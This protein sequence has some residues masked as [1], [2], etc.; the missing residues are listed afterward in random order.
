MVALNRQTIVAAMVASAMV[1]AGCDSG[2]GG[3]GGG[4]ATTASVSVTPSLGKMSNAQV[5]VRCAA[6]GTDMGTGALNSNGSVDIDASGTCAGP[7]VIRVE[8]TAATTY[9]DESANDSRSLPPGVVMRTVLPSLSGDTTVAVTPFTEA[10]TRH[11]ITAAG[12]IN[13]VSAAQV[14]AANT[15]VVDMLLGPGE[16]LNILTPPRV[17]DSEPAA[18]SLTGSEA[19]RY[20]FYLAAMAELGATAAY[21][22]YAAMN[23][24]SD[25]I[26][27][28]T[29]SGATSTHVNYTGSSFATQWSAALLANAD[30]AAA[31]LKTTLGLDGGGGG[32]GGGT[33]AGDLT[34]LGDRNGMKVEVGGHVWTF[35][36]A[37]GDRSAPAGFRRID[38]S[39]ELPYDLTLLN[40]HANIRLFNTQVTVAIQAPGV[41]TC[42]GNVKVIVTATFDSE[43]FGGDY[44]ATTCS[45]N[46]DYVSPLGAVAGVITSA[47]LTNTH[48][49]SIQL[50]NAPFRAYRHVGPG[51]SASGIANDSFISM[52]I[53]S[54]SYEFPA[55]REFQMRKNVTLGGSAQGAGTS[56]PDGTE[57]FSGNASDNLVF[58]VY[59]ASDFFP[60]ART[61]NCGEVLTGGVPVYVS[62]YMG[63]YLAEYVFESGN[64]GGSCTFDITQKSGKYFVGTYTATLVG[65]NPTPLLLTAPQRTIEV[66]GGMRNFRLDVHQPDAGDGTALGS[67]GVTLDI[68]DSNVVFESGDHFLMSTSSVTQNEADRFHFRV[69]WGQYDSAR[70][71][72]DVRNGA[73]GFEINITDIPR[74]VGSYQCGSGYGGV[75]PSLALSSERV[76]SLG[77]TQTQGV[78][79]VLLS[80]ANCTITISKNDGTGVEGT[81]A[82]TL[83]NSALAAIVPGGDATMAFTG[84][85]RLPA[86]TVP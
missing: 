13:A 78:T 24:I 69:D 6:T 81:I 77:A 18:G 55:G 68:T 74:A 54:G 29:L 44:T 23:A 11:A 38:F 73:N 31:E 76:G 37:D 67:S 84:N 10:A 19:D 5:T 48:G 42:G 32:G 40:G 63:M 20:A 12:S 39:Q 36:N 85:F 59:N 82:G 43:P 28:G 4:S 21:P 1:L 49:N 30:Y 47:S 80:G 2:G 66:S 83:V 70:W 53:D 64:A 7:V 14:N 16:T 58:N 9:F 17:W 50:V 15:A 56:T 34:A 27:D 75:Y 79:K 72:Q 41:Q 35:G 65:D 26:K 45:I 33:G 86:L 61:Y 25:D 46:V 52:F 60:G 8:A 57:V 22:A 62:L 51:A 3:G 71:A